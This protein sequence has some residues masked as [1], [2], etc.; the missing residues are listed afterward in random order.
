V[1]GLVSEPLP[2]WEEIYKKELEIAEGLTDPGTMTAA[3]VSALISDRDQWAIPVRIIPE[4]PR[5]Y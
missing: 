3:L 1:L 4:E 2:S 5:L